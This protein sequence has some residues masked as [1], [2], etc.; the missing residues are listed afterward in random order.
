MSKDKTIK[1]AL[2]GVICAALAVVW[3]QKREEARESFQRTDRVLY[4]A[5]VT[6]NESNRDLGLNEPE[7]DCEAQPFETTNE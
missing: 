7:E 3:L 5:C 1:F 4:E 2:V 6:L